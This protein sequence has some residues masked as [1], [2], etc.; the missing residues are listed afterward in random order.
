MKEYLFL[1]SESN[2]KSFDG[3]EKRVKMHKCTFLNRSVNLVR[4]K[5][6]NLRISKEVRKPRGST[7]RQ[8]WEQPSPEMELWVT[9]EKGCQRG[10][11]AGRLRDRV[12]VYVAQHLFI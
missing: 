7:A 6:I 9:N 10:K 4:V 5:I 1:F 11:M 2:E 3:Y 12:V 8:R